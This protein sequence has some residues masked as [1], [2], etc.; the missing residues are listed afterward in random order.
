MSTTVDLSPLEALIGETSGFEGVDT[1][2]R[3]D[4]RRKLE[5]YCS[6]CPIHYS[7]E[8][9]RAHGYKGLVAPAVMAPLMAPGGYW[10]PGEPLFF[11][12]DAPGHFGWIRMNLPNPYALAV[13][14][15]SGWEYT[16]PLYPGDR[17]HGEWGVTEIKP[18][19]TRLGEG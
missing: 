1:L 9:A 17:L 8:V 10:H 7:D 4:I 19:T 16:E 15:T 13:N 5:E 11:A 2:E 12:P 14:A 3:G 6:D 18:R